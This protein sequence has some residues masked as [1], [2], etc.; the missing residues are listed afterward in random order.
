MREQS[1]V[2]FLLEAIRQTES[3][4]NSIFDRLM[5]PRHRTSS[6]RRRREGAA[7]S[8]FLHSHYDRLS[9]TPASLDRALYMFPSPGLLRWCRK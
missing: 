7:R 5:P 3:S 9:S 1:S 8:P 6:Y 4:R 2:G